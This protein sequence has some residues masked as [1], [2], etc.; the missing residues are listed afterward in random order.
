MMANIL[1]LGLST[2]GQPTKKKGEGKGKKP[3]KERYHMLSLSRGNNVFPT[4]TQSVVVSNFKFGKRTV[5]SRSGY[6]RVSTRVEWCS[7]RGPIFKHLQER[8]GGKPEGTKME[9]CIC[10]NRA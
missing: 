8:I 10:G 9:P 5:G 4:E 3:I 6:I 7:T 2:H 1:S